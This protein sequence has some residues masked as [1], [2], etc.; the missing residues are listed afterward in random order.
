MSVNVT[1]K[2]LAVAQKLVDKAHANDGLAP[3]DL[4]RFWADQRIAIA[5]PF[6]EHIPQVAFGAICNWECVFAELGIEQDWALYQRDVDWRLSLSKAYNDKAEAIVGRRLLNEK[7]PEPRPGYPAIKA[8]HDVFEMENRWDD[9]SQCWWLQKG[10]NNADELAALLDRVGKRLENLR[11]FLLPDNWDVEKDGLMA[12][13]IKPSLYRSQRGPVTF[14][15]SLFGV[16]G[17]IFLIHDNPDLAARLRDTILKVMLGKIR[18]HDEEAG[19]TPETAPRGFSFADDNCAMLNADMYE[20]FGY[21]I[22]KGVWDLCS[23]D[24]KDRRSQHSDS[25]MAHIMPV[26]GRCDL[27]GA[28]F[29]PNVMVDEIRKYMP[30]AVI[31]GALAPFTYSRNE[32]VNMVAEFLRDFERSREKRGL[33]FST[34]GSINNGSRLTGMR[35][36]MAAI[37]EYGRFDR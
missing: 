18:I 30:N 19:Y 3:V 27:T 28:N 33:V 12:M 4:D 14:A 16:E 2:H 6:G 21:P 8:L 36:L 9:T 11:D 17:L 22:V 25:D 13:G 7:R 5:D 26:L 34:A 1:E 20:F 32:E 15:T 31:S 35:L 37:Q 23:P 10:A 24:P 29:G